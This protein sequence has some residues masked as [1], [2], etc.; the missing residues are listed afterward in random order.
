MLKAGVLHETEN[1][2]SSSKGALV[3]KSSGKFIVSDGPFAET[4][5]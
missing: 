5:G 1:L 4:K 3:G 2:Q